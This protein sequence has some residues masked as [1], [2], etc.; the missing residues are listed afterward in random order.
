[1][2]SAE[3]KQVLMDML[4]K[5]DEDVE[6]AKKSGDSELVLLTRMKA[7]TIITCLAKLDEPKEGL[8]KAQILAE[9]GRANGVICSLYAMVRDCVIGARLDKDDPCK[10]DD[11]V[12]D[13]ITGLNNIVQM[14]T[15]ECFGEPER[16]MIE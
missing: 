4:H 11:V 13:T 12:A 15:E 9:I 7:D 5:A 16:S 2:I 1:M 6:S 8:D 14:I 10:L 3:A